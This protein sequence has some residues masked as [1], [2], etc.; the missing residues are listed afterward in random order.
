MANLPFFGFSAKGKRAAHASTHPP[1]SLL[2]P[3]SMSLDARRADITED[4]RVVTSCPEINRD[5]L[6]GLQ[7]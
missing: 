5:V 1:S 7:I 3:V 4:G 2:W 6:S